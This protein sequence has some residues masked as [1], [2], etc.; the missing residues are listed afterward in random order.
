MAKTIPLFWPSYDGKAIREE[1]EKLFPLDMSNRWIGQGEKVKEFEKAFGEKYG[2]TYCLGLNSGSSALE[3]AYVLLNLKEGDEVITSVLTCT[4][5]NIP[6][7]RMKAKIVF[8][9]IS[10]NFTIDYEDVKNKIT[11]KTKAIV[12]ITLGGLP[13]DERL[14]DLG[15]PVVVDAA[16]S[17]GVSE[18]KGDYI[19][20]SFQAIKHFTSA[21]G[22][23]L[24]CKNKEDYDR[25]KRL[26]W[27]GIDREAKIANDWQPYKQRE[28]TMDMH[29]A[30]FKFHMNDLTAAIGLTGLKRADEWLAYRQVIANIYNVTMMTVRNT[31]P[32]PAKFFAKS[33]KAQIEF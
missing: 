4:A 30:G 6:L 33:K 31:R 19:C 5:T 9:D 8:A 27:F 13:V 22:G 15:L 10:N 26:R 3:L 28:M 32:V 11:E 18:S 12:A 29:E 14:F 25:A 23:M 2:Y 21:D 1:V 20:Y 16:Q 17:V 7:L 24:V